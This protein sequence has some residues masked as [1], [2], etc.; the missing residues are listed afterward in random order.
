MKGGKVPWGRCI[1]LRPRM[2]ETKKNHCEYSVPGILAKTGLWLAVGVGR[3]PRREGDELAALRY[4]MQR[5]KSENAILR[6]RLR[7][8]RQSRHTWKEKLHTL[9]HV[10]AFSR[11]RRQVENVFG[12]ARLTYYRS[13]LL[14]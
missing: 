2:T 7:G 3:K 13:R 14:G 8:N 1:I 10:E 9:R 5:L 12:I 4:E 11:S 6:R